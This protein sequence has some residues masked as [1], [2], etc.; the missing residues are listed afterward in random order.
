MASLAVPPELTASTTAA[1]PH[2]NPHAERPL[3]VLQVGTV[4]AGGGAA[5]IA[6]ALHQGF[7][8]RGC[9]SWQAV[10]QKTSADPEVFVVPDDDRLL[11]RAV[12]YTGVQR[13]LRQLAG[14]HPG[15]GWGL[16]RRTLRRVTHPAVWWQERRGIEDFEFP[17]SHRVLELAPAPPDILHCHNLHGG[18]FDLRALAPL[19]HRVPT[20]LTLHDAWALSGH[21]AHSLGCDRWTSGCGACPDLLLYPAV[22]QDATGENWRRKEAVYRQSRLY[23]ATPS[24]WLAD[25]VRR[26][27]LA[28]A[29]ADLRV[30]PHGVDLTVFQP[31]SRVAVR[32]RLGLP[33][34]A[35]I[36]VLTA[37]SHY[38]V[39]KDRRT[40][41]AVVEAMGARTAS[42]EIVFVA[43]EGEG[44]AA[45]ASRSRI[46]CVGHQSD[47]A[48]LARFLQAADVYVHATRADTFPTAVL[49]AL[50]CGTPIVATDVGGIPEQ[51]VPAGL[52]QIRA[53]QVGAATGVLVAPRDAA[54]MA[55]AVRT[56]IEHDA[57]RRAMSENA[58]RDARR[59]FDRDRYVDEYLAWY[60]EL[61]A[62]W[63]SWANA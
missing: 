31:A 24:R 51:V 53:R 1:L 34:D 61:S 57:S 50:A 12:G 46:R 2:V 52:D 10:G 47:P 36:V 35:A 4:E 56:L 45:I 21:C 49:E 39:W 26:S 40:M 37:G 33:R 11:W 59:R 28:P 18:Y 20:V 55:D 62:D 25:R 22:R 30:I 38:S 7:R 42:R 13:G 5:A 29:V 32:E 17:G 48:A 16:V 8:A 54:G 14:R 58:V 15:R 44:G 41:S 60:R 6:K 23:V 63:R 27:M 43:L 3:R 9:S 19:S